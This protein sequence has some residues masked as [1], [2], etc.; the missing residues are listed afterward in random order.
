MIEIGFEYYWSN[1]RMSQDNAESVETLIS[2]PQSAGRASQETQTVA[3]GRMESEVFASVD[4]MGLLTTN[5]VR[6]G[7][8]IDVSDLL[9][10]C[11]KPPASILF[12]YESYAKMLG[13]NKKKL[14]TQEQAFISDYSANRKKLY[15]I[16]KPRVGQS[17]ATDW[18]AQM[19]AD[20]NEVDRMFTN[21]V[22]VREGE[23]GEHVPEEPVY[24]ELAPRLRTMRITKD[25]PPLDKNKLFLDPGKFSGD[26]KRAREFM[27]SF[28]R[29]A[30]ANCWNEVQ[31]VRYFPSFLVD[32][33]R[34]WYTTRAMKKPGATTSWALLRNTFMRFYLRSDDVFSIQQQIDHCFQRDGESITQFMPRLLQLF[35]LLKEEKTEQQLVVA[36]KMKL[37]SFYQRQLAPF[38]VR[39]LDRLTEL[40]LRLEANKASTKEAME[41]ERG[42]SGDAS[43]KQQPSSS[44]G[45]GNSG[46]RRNGRGRR[47]ERAERAVDRSLKDSVNSLDLVRAVPT[48]HRLNVLVVN[49]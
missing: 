14:T 16:V 34:L 36:V 30:E 17:G 25:V 38:D 5:M 3:G 24:E 44:G 35:D 46:R 9:A 27:E 42:P 37:R 33:A 29:A 2:V 11:P 31:R 23:V 12:F 43:H 41:R 8:P 1:N 21:E 15:E 49:G 20:R 6:T 48:K 7:R 19:E 47:G 4:P 39:D 26:A 22:E 40:C 18:A 32:T 10:M 45:Q 13:Q 28:E